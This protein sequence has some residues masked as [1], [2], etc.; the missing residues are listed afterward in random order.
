MAS[1][2]TILERT[3]LFNA[4]VQVVITFIKYIIGS[5]AVFMLISS[6][7]TLLTSGSNEENV[8][9]AK[10]GLTW[11]AVGLVLMI[12]ADNVVNN[13][14]FNVSRNTLPGTSGSQASISVARGL[15]EIVGFTNYALILVGPVLVLLVLAGGVLYVTSGGDEERTG[16]AKKII[17]SALIGMVIVYGA[18]ALVSTF[19]IGEF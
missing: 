2:Q 15:D 17:I 16:R 4:Q 3:G 12:I 8:T 19:L 11:S 13:V 6:A 7:L 5:I 1:P 18:F 14:L 9:K 10:S